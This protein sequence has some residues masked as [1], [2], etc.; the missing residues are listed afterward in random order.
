M[1]SRLQRLD[2]DR[3]RRRIQ[4]IAEL[5]D[6]QSLRDRVAPRRARM[7]RLR[8]LVAHRRRTA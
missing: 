4:L 5:T 3:Y 6:A 8:V 1:P 7:E 2:P